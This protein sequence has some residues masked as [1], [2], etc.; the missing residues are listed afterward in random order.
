[1][2][3][4]MLNAVIYTR[5]STEE[6][7]QN[8]SLDSQEKECRAYATRNKLVTTKIFR[9]EG[10]SAKTVSGRPVLKELLAYCLDKKNNV[11]T[12]LVYKIDRWS[13]NVA[14][15]LGIIATLGKCGINVQSVT[16]PTENNAMGKAMRGMMMVMA[17]LDNNVKS[18]RTSSGMK[19]AFE[20]GRWPWG[21][22]IGYLH[23]VVE[24]KKK[25]ILLSAYKPILEK[26]FQEAARNIHTKDKLIEITNSMGFGKLWGTPAN[27]KTIDRIIKKKFYYGVMEAGTWKQEAKGLH[28]PITDEE[29]WMKANV[30]LY[31]KS[32]NQVRVGKSNEFSLKG[33]VRCGGCAK[34]LRASYNRGNG[35]LYPNYHC[36]TKGCERRVIVRKE[37]FENNFLEHLKMFRL[38]DIQKKLLR[39]VLIEKL[40]AKV[41][42]QE[43]EE[44]AILHKIE[45]V[46][47]E[48]M[49]IVKSN[50]KGLLGD[51]EATQ[52]LDKLKIEEVTSVL[53]LSES[54]I[55]RHEAEAIINFTTA[56][57]TNVGKLWVRLDTD[58][59]I[60]LQNAI[61][62]EGV[63][64][65][66]G[67]FG[68][69]KISPSFEL[70][71]QFAEE[72]TPLVTP[73]GLE[74]AI[75]R[76]KT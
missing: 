40:E 6:Q 25:L 23:T 11:S 17:E 50:N 67:I 76:M 38:S 63:V 29:T 68:T 36:T 10:A 59:K 39:I 66:D 21:A 69:T 49:A 72:K 64:Y 7:T 20:A 8:Y 5:V 32:K 54:K 73:A 58:R 62:P 57:L 1:M 22:P 2:N 16:E 51:D 52:L 15:G 3:S 27:Y 30:A 70:I 61:F 42:N 46:R 60:K 4:Q 65:R 75:F 18:E 71:Q 44:I 12:V 19:A 35:G 9:E 26:L 56:L 14:E 43:K 13:R 33:I 34:P 55:D 47:S 24:G 28:E 31:G 74:P 41:R 37:K 48:R 45:E 53:E